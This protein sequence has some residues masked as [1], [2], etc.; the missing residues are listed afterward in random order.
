MRHF[1]DEFRTVSLWVHSFLSGE[2]MRWVSKEEN[3]HPDADGK[4]RAQYMEQVQYLRRRT[5]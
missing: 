5:V 1:Y 3:A 2:L 4:P